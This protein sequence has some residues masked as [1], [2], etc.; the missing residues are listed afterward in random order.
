MKTKVNLSLDKDVIGWALKKV[1]HL[2]I[3]KRSTAVNAALRVAMDRDL[4]ETTKSRG[5]QLGVQKSQ[6]VEN[7][8]S[9]SD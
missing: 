2:G 6:V 1:K 3:T 7:E 9:K 8:A 4:N 5:V